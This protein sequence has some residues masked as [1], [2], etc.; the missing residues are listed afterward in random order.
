MSE[1]PEVIDAEYAET[2]VVTCVHCQQRNRI[3]IPSDKKYR[4]GKCHKPLEREWFHARKAFVIPA[5]VLVGLAVFTIICAISEQSSQQSSVQITPP[6]LKPI[7]FS[8][9]GAV[10]VQ[11]GVPATPP[12]AAVSVF[13]PVAP[14]R[15]MPVYSPSP[16]PSLDDELQK[17][18]ERYQQQQQYQQQMLNEARRANDDAEDANLDRELE[19]TRMPLPDPMDNYYKQQSLQ[20]QQQQLNDQEWYHLE[21]QNRGQ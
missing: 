4:C 8:D 5:I 19:S 12:V 17:I 20:I 7:D 6:N 11:Q 15:Y 14:V 1:T 3:T 18:D 16:Q 21:Q 10:P 9:L 13:P 2:K